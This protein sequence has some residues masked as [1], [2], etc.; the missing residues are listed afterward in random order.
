M[1]MRSRKSQTTNSKTKETKFWTK[2]LQAMMSGK[3]Q[4]MKL[5]SS[6]SHNLTKDGCAAERIGEEDSITRGIRI[7]ISITMSNRLFAKYLDAHIERINK[8]I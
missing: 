2:S 6:R 8:Y 3:I 4:M 7:Q 1:Q 5:M